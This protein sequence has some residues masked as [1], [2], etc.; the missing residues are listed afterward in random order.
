MFD[1]RVIFTARGGRARAL[2]ALGIA[3]GLL[4]SLAGSAEAQFFGWSLPPAYGVPESAMIAPGEIYRMVA[5][6]GYRIRDRLQRNGRVYL[7]DVVDRRG[8]AL[9]LI[10]DAYQGDI[11]QRFAT[12]P[13]RPVASIPQPQ[14]SADLY[15]QYSAYPA[16]PDAAPPPAAAVQTEVAPEIGHKTKTE[17]RRSHAKK[18]RTATRETGS[19]TAEPARSGP[20]RQA[21][22]TEA[23]PPRPAADTVAP[24]PAA[25]GGPATAATPPQPA[26]QKPEPVT[27]AITPA[28]ASAPKQAPPKT[29]GPGYANGVP[30]NPLD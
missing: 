6:H 11:L 25:R 30:I 7:I 19:A 23:V 21:V 14:S 12:A 15:P 3:G 20:A 22:H 18:T 10:I 5:D 9:R 26:V 8:R 13:P 17:A 27:A 4:V 28:P 2:A 24:Q 1:Y 29:T 16:Y